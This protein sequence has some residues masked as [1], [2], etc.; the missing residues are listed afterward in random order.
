M[1]GIRDKD[2][3]P[4]QKPRGPS[5]SKVCRTTAVKLRNVYLPARQRSTLDGPTCTQRPSTHA[6]I[7]VFIESSGYCATGSQ[8]ASAYAHATPRHSN[9]LTVIAVAV[10]V[11]EQAAISVRYRLAHLRDAVATSA[12]LHRRAASSPPGAIY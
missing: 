8:A 2:G 9:S 4:L 10:S 3:A 7:R 12:L 5:V 11:L 1:T 6:C